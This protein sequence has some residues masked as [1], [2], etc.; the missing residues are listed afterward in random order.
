MAERPM[1]IAR[2]DGAQVDV[3]EV[4]IESATERW[5]EIVL[6][7]GSVLRVKMNVGVVYR[8]D[9]EYDP[10]GNPSYVIKG[11]PGV[12]VDFDTRQIAERD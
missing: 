6:E 7:D 10:E 1:K 12:I 11:S 9:G 4:P 8:V 2:P 3:H 5:T